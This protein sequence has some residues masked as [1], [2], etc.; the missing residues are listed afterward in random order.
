MPAA[1]PALPAPP[2][3]RPRSGKWCHGGE[4]RRGAEAWRGAA[5]N[6]GPLAPELTGGPCCPAAGRCAAPA[7]RR[8]TT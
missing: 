5:N 2:H 6:A 1:P 8:R 3:I 4:R 7:E